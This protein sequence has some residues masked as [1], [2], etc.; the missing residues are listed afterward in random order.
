MLDDWN[1]DRVNRFR[2]EAA[3]RGLPTDEVD[4]W[5]RR[6]LPGVYWASGGDGPVSA[7]LGGAPLLPVDAPDPSFPFVASVDCALLPPGAAGLPLPSDGHLLFFA[8]PDPG[9]TGPV[10]DAVRHVSAHTPTAARADTGHEP[11]APQEMCTTWHHLSPPDPES[12]AEA[13]WEEPDDEQYE[14]ADELQSAWTHVGGSWPV[15]T[16][17]LGGHP[18]VINDDPLVLARDSE[19]EAEDADEWVLLATWRCDADVAE[20]DL[21]VISWLIRRQDL[22][23]LRFDRVY[24]HVG[25]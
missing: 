12:F 7:R 1:T 24:G 25:M 4:T 11:F 18:I 14:L 15:W 2:A 21:G 8:D 17:A 16:F 6:A 23:S 10:S 3:S 20:L 19:P 22:A 13:R 5:I 9:F